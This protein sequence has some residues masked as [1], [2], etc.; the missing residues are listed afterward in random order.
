MTRNSSISCGIVLQS[1]VHTCQAHI[2]LTIRN[3]LRAHEQMN[4]IQL[5]VV[6]YMGQH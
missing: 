2:S 1:A 3:Q 5:G 4:L 6:N